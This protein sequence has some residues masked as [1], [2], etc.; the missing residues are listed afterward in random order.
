VGFGF[1]AANAA[2]QEEPVVEAQV[3]GRVTRR[4]AGPF[5]LGIGIGLWVPFQR[6]RF[7]YVDAAGSQE[8]LFRTAPVVGVVDASIGLAFP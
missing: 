5:D 6:A 7:Y 8:E 3:A 1:S 4:V 2:G